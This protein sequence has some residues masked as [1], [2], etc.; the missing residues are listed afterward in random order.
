MQGSR[1]AAA[2]SA[3]VH[4]GA[5]GARI[6]LHTELLSSLRSCEGT[7]SSV[8]DSLVGENFCVG[9]PPDLQIIM[10][11]LGAQNSKHCSSGNEFEDHNLF[12]WSKIHIHRCALS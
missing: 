4:K 12:L 2:P 5:G 9:K 10:V 11:L 8:I 6:A 1:G 7:F 3:L